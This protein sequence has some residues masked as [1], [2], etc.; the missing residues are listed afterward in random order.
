MIDL[1]KLRA[2]KG[3]SLTHNGM[4][5]HA[6]FWAAEGGMGGCDSCL[7]LVVAAVM[8]EAAK[9]ADKH[10]EVC[11]ETCSGAATAIREAARAH[12]IHEK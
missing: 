4:G 10:S 2:V 9:I 7:R 3:C 5:E 12:E 8:E 11:P 1:Y 6:I